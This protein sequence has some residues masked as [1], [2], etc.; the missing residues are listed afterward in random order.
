MNNIYIYIYICWD[1]FNSIYMYVGIVSIVNRSTPTKEK[2][3]G[4]KS[5]LE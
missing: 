5:L 3:T 1:S 4:Q 2:K